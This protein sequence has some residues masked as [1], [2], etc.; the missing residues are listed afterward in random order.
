[1]EFNRYF[2]FLIII[3]VLVYFPSCR[4]SE[5]NDNGTEALFKDTVTTTRNASFDTSGKT[6]PQL[7]FLDSIS[8]HYDLT[9]TQIK[10]HTKIDSD[11]FIPQNCKFTGDSVI[12]YKYKY[13]VAIINY[14]DGSECE[15]KFLLIFDSTKSVNTDFKL[16]ETNCDE[17][18]SAATYLENTYQIRNDSIFSTDEII[19]N[20]RTKKI[21]ITETFWTINKSGRITKETSWFP[22]DIPMK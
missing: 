17:D 9:I 14:D 11:Y 10:L 6:A 13:L 8:N 18:E 21:R 15:D 7:N 4:Y 22:N 16:V 1:M 12:S 2:Q 5:K 19:K 20:E 3:I